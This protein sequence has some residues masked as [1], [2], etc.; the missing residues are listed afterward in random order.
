MRERNDPFGRG[1]PETRMAREGTASG[2]SVRRGDR[3]ASALALLRGVIAVETCAV[4][5]RRLRQAA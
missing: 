2:R 4:K 3:G 1:D 5:A